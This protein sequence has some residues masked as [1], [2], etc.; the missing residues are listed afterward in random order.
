MQQ[1]P[2]WLLKQGNNSTVARTWL[3]A[4]VFSQ[5]FFFFFSLLNQ[6]YHR[7]ETGF[8]T[9]R[10]MNCG[11]SHISTS[12]KL[13]QT[14]R[15]LNWLFFRRPTLNFN[16]ILKEKQSINVKHSLGPRCL[17]NLCGHHSLSWIV[18]LILQLRKLNLK[19]VKS[20]ANSHSL[21]E[22]EL[23]MKSSF[24]EPK[25]SLLTIMR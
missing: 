5:G 25:T 19:K 18:I 4:S 13:N 16:L 21:K 10:R 8:R 2:R 22:V 11:Q 7:K 24:W 15:L 12:K 1:T 3:R 9:L 20:C 6:H 14:T 17:L 23:G